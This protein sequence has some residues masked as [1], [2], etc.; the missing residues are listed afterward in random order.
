MRPYRA[1]L[2][3]VVL[4]TIFLQWV[5]TQTV[6]TDNFNQNITV[7]SSIDQASTFFIPLFL[8]PLLLMKLLGLQR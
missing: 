2:T 3:L 7:D 1:F 4:V 5:N 8:S 6:W